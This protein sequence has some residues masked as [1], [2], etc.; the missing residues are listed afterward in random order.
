MQ[1]ISVDVRTRFPAN[2]REIQREG[3]VEGVDSE[4]SRS[5]LCLIRCRSGEKVFNRVFAPFVEEYNERQREMAR[6]KEQGRY[7]RNVIDNYYQKVVHSPLG[8]HPFAEVILSIGNGESNPIE[9]PFFE[10]SLKV[11]LYYLRVFLSRYNRFYVC[12]AVIHIDEPARPM[13]LHIGFIPVSMR[14]RGPRVG[15]GLNGALEQTKRLHPGPDGCPDYRGPRKL[16]LWALDQR[17]ILEEM[18]AK[19]GIPIRRRILYDSYEAF[20]DEKLYEEQSHAYLPEIEKAREEIRALKGEME[21][22]TVRD[23]QSISEG[24]QEAI[25]KLDGVIESITRKKGYLEARASEIQKLQDLAEVEAIPREISDILISKREA[26]LREMIPDALILALV[27]NE[28]G[29]LGNLVRLI[30]EKDTNLEACLNQG[31]FALLLPLLAKDSGEVPDQGGT[32]E[33][34]ISPEGIWF[35]FKGEGERRV[36]LP[37]ML[38]L[39]AIRRLKEKGME[40]G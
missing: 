36:L 27:W 38:V 28:E 13:H 6:R 40:T 8:A 11:Y 14:S 25:R 9:G 39:S 1:E 22:Q 12:S 32:V 15:C 10:A 4:M 16:A 35:T 18:C 30:R 26:A 24:R 31:D 23:M 33:G 2:F 7:L 21:T 5:N 29:M 37:W 20:M 3:P 34:A 19:A 17:K